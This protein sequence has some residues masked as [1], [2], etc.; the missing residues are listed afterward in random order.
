[1]RE[2]RFFDS[3]G[4]G[5]VRSPRP[6]YFNEYPLSRSK[7]QHLQIDKENIYIFAHYGYVYCML[8]LRGVVTDDPE[9]EFLV[10]GGG[11]GSIKIWSLDKETGAIEEWCQIGECSGDSVLSM[12]LDGTF[13]ISGTTEGK[14]NVWDL[15]T[16]QIVRV[17]K[18]HV[19]DVLTLAVGGGCLFAAG[20]NGQIEVRHRFEKQ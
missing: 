6:E 19:T 13:L 11:D 15:E 17:L 2:D 1:M 7:T 9:E 20:A 14:I 3:A 10:S 16:R 12:V 4:P 18:T 8:L 5:G